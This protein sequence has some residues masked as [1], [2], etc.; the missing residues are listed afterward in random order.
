MLVGLVGLVLLLQLTTPATIHPIGILMVF[1]SIYLLV[2]GALTFFMFWGSRL[3]A[4]ILSSMTAKQ[5]RTANLVTT[6]QYATVVSLAPVMLLAMRTVGAV[7]PSD[8]LFVVIF[9]SLACFYIWRRR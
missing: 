5:Y 6:Y 1:V 7:N 2:L 8:I 3:Y 4:R 9:V